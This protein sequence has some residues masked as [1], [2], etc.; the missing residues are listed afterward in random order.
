M[1]YFFEEV[2]STNDLA[3]DAQFG[4]SDVLWAE[5]QTAGR[6]QRGHTW[7]SVAGEN[8]TFTLVVEPQ[9]L[10]ARDQFFLSA[11]SA[12]ALCDCF[13][14]FG[15]ESRI[16]WTNDIYVEDRKLV[17]ILIEHFYAGANLRKTLIGIGINVNQTEFD[18]SLPN[19]TSMQLERGEAFDREAILH[20]FYDCFMARYAQLEAGHTATLLAD[21]HHLI[22]RLGAVQRFRLPEGEEFEATIE[23]IEEDGALKLLHGSGERQSYHFKEVEFVVNCTKKTKKG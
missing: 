21:Y 17:G 9:F 14:H 8:L 11:C 23:G 19:P 16:K 18:P 10:P 13:T 12:L 5:R 7:L 1:I 20:R 2:T 4:H 22:Y 6:G 3:R 15:I